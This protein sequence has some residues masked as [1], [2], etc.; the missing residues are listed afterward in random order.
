MPPAQGAP[1]SSSRLGVSSSDHAG[2]VVRSGQPKKQA[3][4]EGTHCSSVRAP[5]RVGAASAGGKPTQT[6]RTTEHRLPATSSSSTKADAPREDKDRRAVQ[7]ARRLEDEYNLTLQ[8]LRVLE[9]TA[10]ERE[11]QLGQALDDAK[12]RIDSLQGALDDAQ[13]RLATATNDLANLRSLTVEDVDTSPLLTLFEDINDE[14]NEVAFRFVSD[15][16][17]RDEEVRLSHIRR[18]EEVDVR[19]YRRHSAYLA[20]CAE[21]KLAVEQALVPAIQATCHSV[22]QYFIF[23]PFSPRTQKDADRFLLHVQ[24][25]IRARESQEYSARWRSITYKALASNS[26]GNDDNLVVLDSARNIVTEAGTLTGLFVDARPFEAVFAR[27]QQACERVAAMALQ[28]QDKAQGTHLAY[29]YAAFAPAANC[30]FL[31][32]EM[33]AEELPE[34]GERDRGRLR[35]ALT[36]GAGLI[37]C[38]AGETRP[39]RVLKKAHVI[40]LPPGAM[41]TEDRMQE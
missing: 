16:K 4:V 34:G 30:V 3:E 24:R 23:K 17:L 39:P 33:R 31:D 20:S 2:S 7:D 41:L 6:S 40:L 1:R 36:I 18:L 28:W 13:R 26:T 11:K 27:L 25:N 10:A 14:V 12:I 38:K 22:F 8:R 9:E 32:A 35:V 37:A 19:V 29:D 21:Q 5:A 15:L